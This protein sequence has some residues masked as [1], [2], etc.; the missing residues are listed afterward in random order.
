MA[1]YH[2]S[3]KNGIVGAAKNHAE[4]IMR[5]GRYSDKSRKEELKYHNSNLPHWANDAV[6]FFEKAD[7]LFTKD[8]SENV[9]VLSCDIK[10]LSD[11]CIKFIKIDLSTLCN[12]F[13]CRF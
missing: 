12:E 5:L 7:I 10:N 8:L 11:R 1:T 4:Y 13:I 6:D 3:L 9:L 2:L